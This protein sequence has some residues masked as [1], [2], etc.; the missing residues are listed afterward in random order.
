MRSQRG[1]IMDEC[2]RT[3]E[4]LRA[5]QE[6]GALAA[7]DLDAVER[8]CGSCAGCAR[9]FSAVLP[10]VQR[11]VRGI[12]VD[13]SD[14]PSGSFTDA[15]MERVGQ[16][17]PAW[18]SP[19]L[20]WVMAAAASVVLLAGIGFG[21]YRLGTGRAT[22]EVL[23]RFQLV[24]PGAQSVALVGSFTGWEASKLPMTDANRDGVWEISVRL[25][26]D[27]VHTYNFL[28]D[29]TRWVPD[30]AAEG[31]VDDGFGGR[32]SIVTL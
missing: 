19:R 17:V 5:W 22:G 21:A 15:V 28:I 32:S 3:R 2:A 14:G 6:S 23:V 4:V 13:P 16:R 30:P 29:G 31:Q 1:P 25:R 26:K 27:A 7:A 8:H 12:P 10:F 24:A 9:E 11:D 18:S 20:T